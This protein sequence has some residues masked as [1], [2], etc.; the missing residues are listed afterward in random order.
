[1]Y[2]GMKIRTPILVSFFLSMACVQADEIRLLASDLIS[3]FISQPLRTLAETADLDLKINSSGSL[4]AIDRMRANETDL[5]IIAIPEGSETPEGFSTYPFAYDAAVI[6]VNSGNP[7]DEISMTRLGGIY[8]T[9]EEYNF[10]TWGQLGLSGWAS[11]NIK[12]LAGPAED[13]ISLEIFR[14]GVLAGGPMKPSVGMLR[15]NEIEEALAGNITTIGILS[16]LP[17]NKN[18]KVLMLS[19]AEGSPAY[20]PSLENIH[21]GDYPLRLSFLVIFNPRD[22][23]KVKPVLRMLLSEEV[24]AALNTNMLFSLP[25]SVRNQLLIDLNFQQ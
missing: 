16:Q 6:A 21:V 13:S 9:N 5:S 12:P 1:M 22:T 23:D 2:L 10:N 18:L 3:H 7:L 15:D 14:H 25:D 20:G 24:A 4:P 11:R 8:G 17:K 19:R